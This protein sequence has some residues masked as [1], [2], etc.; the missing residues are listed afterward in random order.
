MRKISI[1]IFIF[2]SIFIFVPR[3]AAWSD[4]VSA[5]LMP[6]P[7]GGAGIPGEEAESALYGSEEEGSEDPQALVEVE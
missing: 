5:V 3:L 7:R 4:D 6:S 1:Y 2:A